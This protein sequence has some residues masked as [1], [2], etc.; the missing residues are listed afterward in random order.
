MFFSVAVLFAVS[1]GAV[2]VLATPHA[3]HHNALHRRA[4]A[5]RVAPPSNSSDVAVKRQMPQN[6]PSVTSF[7]PSPTASIPTPSPSTGSAS[8]PY[9]GQGTFFARSSISHFCFL[10]F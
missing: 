5:V 6:T 4:A 1:L 7:G 3:L 8:V 10:P 9:T 2:S